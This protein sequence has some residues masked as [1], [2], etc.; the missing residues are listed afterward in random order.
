MTT[1][2]SVSFENEVRDWIDGKS[3]FLDPE[4]EKAWLFDIASRASVRRPKWFEDHY[5]AIC[6]AVQLHQKG[7]K[8][9]KTFQG[10]HPPE[11]ATENFRRIIENLIQMAKEADENI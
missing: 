5:G 2:E 3:H 9:V 6:N 10:Q 1:D 7:V 8:G 11:D 4:E